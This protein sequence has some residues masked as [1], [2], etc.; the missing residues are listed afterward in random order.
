MA[1][2]PIDP[3]ACAGAVVGGIANSAVEGLAEALREGSKFIIKTSVGWWLNVDSIDLQGSGAQAMRGQLRYVALAVAIG[4]MMWGGLRMAIRRNSEPAWDVGA[5]LARLAAVSSLGFL[6]PQLLL[7]AGD[8]FSV[9]VLD[10]ATSDRVAERLT[11]VA[12]L[13]GVTAPGAVIL[14]AILMI[15]AGVVQAMLMFFREGGIIILTGVLVLSA[16]GGMNSMSKSWFPRVSGWL[17]ALILYKPMAALV[18][19][20]ALNQIGESDDPRNFLIGLAMLVLAIVA[21]PAMMKFFTWAAPGAV[22]AASGMGGAASA[23]AAGIGAAGA[24]RGLGGG[25][26]SASDQVTRINQGLGLPSGGSV[27]AAS[28]SSGTGAA[29]GASAGGGGAAA[30][31]AAAGAPVAGAVLMAAQKARDMGNAAKK[32]ASGAMTG[33][34]A[35]G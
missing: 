24:M 32:T 1:P 28:A 29:A 16:A 22:S 7:A 35:D 21:L 15:V 3:T 30:G 11:M 4:G 2:C 6:V 26:G 5:G 8:D 18:Y 33:E 34:G 14:G 23:A 19:A 12:G 17:L 10:Q 9:W 27:S 31:G 20:A 13:G 25:G